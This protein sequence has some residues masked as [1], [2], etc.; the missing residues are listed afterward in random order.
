MIDAQPVGRPLLFFTGFCICL[1]MLLGGATTQGQWTDYVL[2]IAFAP[3]TLI[4]LGRISES[5]ISGLGKTVVAL[6]L[7][8]LLVQFLPVAHPVNPF[9]NNAAPVVQAQIKPLTDIF[10]GG[11]FWSPALGRSAESALFT[12]SLLGFAVFV[13]RLGDFDQ[14]RLVRFFVA[15][16]FLNVVIAFIQT[17]YNRFD[18]NSLFFPY[19]VNVG[20]FANENHFSSL[21]YCG[22][23]FAGFQFIFL[24]KQKFLYFFSVLFFVFILFAYNSRAGMLIAMIISVPVYLVFVTH[25]NAPWRFVLAEAVFVA[26]PFVLLFYRIGNVEDGT[27]EGLN[28]VTLTALLHYFPFGSGLGSFVHIYPMF[29]TVSAIGRSFINHAHNDWLELTLEL[30]V[31][32]PVIVFLMALI[33]IQS[34]WR[35]GLSGLAILIIAALLLHSIVDYPLR[36]MGIGIIFAYSIGVIISTKDLN[37]HRPSL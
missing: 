5:R 2:Y 6:I 15:G 9:Q 20:V 16:T 25:Q 23:I 37:L 13:A 27:R 34:K 3:F 7:V 29:D 32:F 26:I 35:D 18:S 31:L 12:I 1:A 21:I 28:A 33:I 19:Q 10:N 30:G 17:S 24:N 8:V 11:Q 22:I 36:T 4:G 14:A